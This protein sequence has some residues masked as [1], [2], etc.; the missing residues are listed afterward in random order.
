MPKGTE[1]QKYTLFYENLERCGRND[2]RILQLM[3]QEI[4]ILRS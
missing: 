2:S 3:L 1:S 4:Q